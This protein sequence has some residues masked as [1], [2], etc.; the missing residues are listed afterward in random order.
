MKTN[1]VTDPPVA[2][3]YTR[4]FLLLWI[5][6]FFMT[7][8]IGCFFLFPLYIKD[9]G[10]SES[11]IGI[12]MGAVTIS[13]V[14]LRPWISQAVDR[15]GRKKSFLLGTFSFFILPFFYLF[16]Q[17]DISD[18]YVPLIALRIIQGLGIALCFT[19]AFTI[20]ADIVPQ[21]RLNEG[22]GMFGVT[23]LIGVATGPAISEPIINHF[24]YDAYFLT[25]SA[26]AVFSLLLLLPLPETMVKNKHQDES[27]SFLDVLKMK[28]IFGTGVLTIFFGF[29]LATQGSFVSPFAKSLGV[30]NISVYFIAYSFGAV[31]A[32]VFGS[33][34]A[35]RLG[36]L[37][38]I[39]WALLLIA[40]G[41]LSL[42][43]VDNS[44]LL[45]ISG[46]ITGLGHG[47]LFP[48]LNTLMIRNEPKQIRGK[49]NGIFT[50]SID[51]GLLMGAIGF[52]YIGEWFGYKLIFI[53]TF[54]ALILGL[55]FFYTYIRKVI[56]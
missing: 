6:N 46:F 35:D 53:S 56:Q 36:E 11:D 17:G 28:K 50:G 5:S 16:F 10:G 23:G 55:V 2:R 19:A 14:L 31:L 26:I 34:L 27:I 1:S 43:I 49:I 12:L 45:I 30:P 39:P 40:T 24:G 22:I 37:R 15:F 48:S 3:L 42:V 44:F 25:I 38:V 33:K 29:A 7:T 52:G 51:L 54:L 13:S 20:I 8:C 4:N 18:F 32:R 41:F 9:H 21:E 47:F